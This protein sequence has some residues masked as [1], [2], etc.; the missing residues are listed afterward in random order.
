M[1]AI[2]T[3]NQNDNKMDW[4]VDLSDGDMKNPDCVWHF[5]TRK[6]ANK[7]IALIE[8]GMEITQASRESRK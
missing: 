3:W 2:K 7:F 1:K 4:Q 8:L 5:S 6:Q